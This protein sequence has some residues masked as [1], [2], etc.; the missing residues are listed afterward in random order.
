MA[1]RLAAVSFCDN[2]HGIRLMDIKGGI[3]P[4]R[5]D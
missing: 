1:L 5:H 3:R 2:P 4:V